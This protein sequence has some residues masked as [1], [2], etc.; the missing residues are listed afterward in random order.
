MSLPEKAKIAVIGLGYVGLPLAVALSRHFPVLG[1][2]EDLARFHA[3]LPPL[4]P[5][6]A[7]QGRAPEVVTAAL[8]NI[9]ELM[10]CLH[11]TDERKALSGIRRWTERTGEAIAEPLA[12]RLTG[13]AH[14]ECHGDLHLENLLLYG[15]RIVAFDALEFDPKLREIDVI[16]ETAFLVMDLLAHG[17]ESFAYRF[18]GRYLEVTGDYDGLSVLRFYLVERALIRAKVRALRAAQTATTADDDDHLP[19][20]ELAVRLTTPSRPVLAI[21]HGYSGSGKTHVTD[22]LIGRLPAVRLPSS[23]NHSTKEAE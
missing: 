11:G 12:Q 13:G 1:F 18:L 2:A 21:T 5:L 3:N 22:E 17:H 16:N 19:Y 6:E 20:L 7:P 9:G 14:R 23:P 10:S 15:G 4:P 8:D